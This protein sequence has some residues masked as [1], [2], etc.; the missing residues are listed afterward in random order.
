MPAATASA[1]RRAKAIGGLVIAI[2]RTVVRALEQTGARDGVVHAGDGVADERIGA[3]S[4][5]RIVDA[6]LSG[7]HEPDTSHYQ[8]LRTFADD[9][10]LS[11][12]SAVLEACGYRSH[13]YGDSMLVENRAAIGGR[14]AA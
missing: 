10:V 6:I 11:R 14:F 5:L 1:I 3:P 9:A 8:V 2:G 12:A 7:T 13:E 4:Q